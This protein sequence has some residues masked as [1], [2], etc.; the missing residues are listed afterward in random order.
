MK[1]GPPPKCR[2]TTA[3]SHEVRAS[4]DRS[5][6]V[7]HTVSLLCC[8]QE[9]DKE[10]GYYESPKRARLEDGYYD[11]PQRVKLHNMCQAI[12]YSMHFLY[13]V[14]PSC[15]NGQKT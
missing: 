7:H 15:R 11:S 8:V 9:D 1:D 10:E 2:K 13:F 12:L 3:Y 5:I 14:E 4:C 6:V